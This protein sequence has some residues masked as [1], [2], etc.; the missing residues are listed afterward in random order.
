MMVI[1]LV[2]FLFLFLVLFLWFS[3]YSLHAICWM[4]AAMYQLLF[5]TVLSS[6]SIGHYLFG[7][8]RGV[9]FLFFFFL[10][11]FSFFP[12]SAIR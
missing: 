7:Y 3:S 9:P 10:F 8:L 5:T 1:S 6:S 11:D 12:V 4:I 2:V